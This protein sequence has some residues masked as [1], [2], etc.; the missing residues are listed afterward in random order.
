VNP[1][2]CLII[3][4][5]LAGLLAAHQLQVAGF[6]VTVL[7]KGRGVGGRMATRR[8]AGPSPEPAVFDYGAQFFT[9]RDPAFGRW[10]DAWQ[11]AGIVSEWSRGFAT[12]DG[13]YYADGHPRYRCPAGMTAIAKALAQTLPVQLNQ[14]VAAVSPGGPG[15]LVTTDAGRQFEAQALVL[16]PPVP[17][18]L[19]LLD[20]GDFALPLADRQHLEQISYEPCIALLALLA[21]P[22]RMPEPGGMWPIGE[23]IAW[24]ADN[25]HKGVSPVPGAVTIHAGPEFSQANWDADDGRIIDRLLDAAGEWL[26]DDLLTAQIQRWR[27]SKP[28]QTYPEPFLA[29]SRPAP[30]ILAGDAFA[31]PRVEGA[32]L[33][34]LAAAD[35]LVSHTQSPAE[36]P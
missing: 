15:W 13:S 21:A 9:V 6:E 33:S 11:A 20:A 22:S 30:L 28:V 12:A 7:D 1:S 24:L 4:A 8:M 32:A 10:V 34:G 16:T 3:G 35:W 19:A 14:R 17:Q 31:G 36:I 25:Y 29:F 2:S 26:G 5:G 27:Y 23:P 18:S